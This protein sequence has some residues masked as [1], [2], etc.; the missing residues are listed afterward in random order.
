MEQERRDCFPWDFPVPSSQS[1][2]RIPLLRAV[3]GEGR[4]QGQDTPQLPLLL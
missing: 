3:L 2:E 4:V 1:E